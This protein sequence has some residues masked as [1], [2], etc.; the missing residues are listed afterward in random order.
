[1]QHWPGHEVS[2]HFLLEDNLI[3][4]NLVGFNGY[5]GEDRSEDECHSY[6]LRGNTIRDNRI[7]ARFARVH[8]CTVEGNQFIGNVD[9]AIRL[10]GTP[11][12][13][14]GD[15]RFE[16]NAQDVVETTARWVSESRW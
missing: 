9:S 10:E 13:Q 6:H 15:N 16:G 3:E 1:V 4:T 11:G 14:V 2:H 7:G 5:T 8:D 12:V